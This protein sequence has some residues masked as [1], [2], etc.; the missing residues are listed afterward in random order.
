MGQFLKVS[1]HVGCLM[2]HGDGIPFM[3][4]WLEFSLPALQWHSLS[5]CLMCS[6][7]SLVE[8]D[9]CKVLHYR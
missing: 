3:Y 9:V 5:I 6:P 2:V 8:S 7:R 4:L 1:L